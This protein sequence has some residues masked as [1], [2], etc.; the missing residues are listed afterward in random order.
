[1]MGQDMRSQ[2]VV[3]VGAGIG[4]LVAAL[5]LAA[6]GLAGHRG[7]ARGGPG[8][9]MR[10][11]AIGGAPIDAGPTVFTMRRVFEEIFADAGASLARPCHAATRS[12]SWRATP[13][14]PT[15]GSICLPTSNRSADAIGAFAGPAEAPALSASSARTRGASTRRSTQPFIRAT[16]PSLARL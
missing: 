3:V 14:A 11:I 7:R 4:G 6:R 10:E 13:G 16:Q 12:E 15:S 1:M 9:K 2:R 8:G 5:A